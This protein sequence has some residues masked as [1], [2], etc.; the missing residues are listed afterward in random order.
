MIA[1]VFSAAAIRDWSRARM[2]VTF[3]DD[4]ED[5]DA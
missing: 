1:V 4:K 2:P 3:H 5:E